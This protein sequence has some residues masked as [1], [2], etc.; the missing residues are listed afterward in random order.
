[1]KGDICML[2][3][4]NTS[5]M[6]IVE[7]YR[8]LV[9]MAM[10]DPQTDSLEERET[11]TKYMHECCRGNASAR[12]Y[13]IEKIEEIL[14]ENVSDEERERLKEIIENELN[15][16]NNKLYERVD[17]S[18]VG[19]NRPVKI[20]FYQL[21]EACGSDEQ[22]IEIEQINSGLLDEISILAREL[23]KKVYGV[24]ILDELW[25]MRLNNI[26]IHDMDKIR[27]ELPTGVWYT[28][29]DC[30]FTDSE[31]VVEVAKKLL[32][33]GTATSDLTYEECKRQTNLL[34]GS[35]ITVALKPC[36][37]TNIIAIK[38]FSNF[39]VT[40]ENMIANGTITEEMI[41]D[42]ECLAKGRANT[43]I[44]GGINTGKTTFGMMYVDLLPPNIKIGMLDPTK[45]FDIQKMYP[46][47]DII[48]L[49]ETEKYNLNNQFNTLFTLGRDVL[50][51]SEAKSYEVEQMIK[52]M[53]R[54]NNGSFCTLHSANTKDV[55]MNIAYMC[56]EGETTQDIRTLTSR[57]SSAL[58]IIIRMRHFKDGRRIVDE[59]SEV[60]ATGN[61]DN[62]FKINKMYYWNEKEKKVVRNKEFK[63]SND[64]EESLLYFGCSEDD[65]AFL[66]RRE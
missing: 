9:T 5:M 33:Q 22:N 20:S 58:D 50:G 51:I 16:Y 15:T 26:E 57:I 27:V 64:L 66:N 52:G 17:L 31:E 59:I 48:I 2:Q 18:N 61:L 54:G 37:A 8:N 11:H 23:Y 32:S 45:D 25:R 19:D 63:L 13:I 62:P 29:S 10:T 49:Y 35:R 55:V 42:I 28:I 34:D 6:N 41:K 53:L 1:M 21:L 38:K 4:Y 43:V 14:R 46:N 60:V 24:D 12:S 65:I 44:A 7:N 30:N 3:F 40:K 56:Q 39:I 36:S 47:R